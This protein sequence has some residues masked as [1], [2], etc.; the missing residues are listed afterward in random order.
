MD[1]YTYMDTHCPDYFIFSHSYSDELRMSRS[2][3]NTG[4]Y[5][6]FFLDESHYL[7]IL[8]FICCS[9]QNHTTLIFICTAVIL[10]KKK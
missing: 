8:N 10:E 6:F 5:N 9:S 2:H 4:S 1:I 3:V 7:K